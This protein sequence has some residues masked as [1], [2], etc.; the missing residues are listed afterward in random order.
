VVPKV[1][2]SRQ[3]SNSALAQRRLSP[4]PVSLR[5]ARAQLCVR[6]RILVGLSFVSVY[7]GIHDPQPVL[8]RSPSDKL[9]YFV[10]KGVQ[11]TSQG[12]IS[13]ACIKK[14]DRSLP[15]SLS[16]KS[17]RIGTSMHLFTSSRDWFC[18]YNIC[19]S[20][21][22]NFMPCLTILK[23]IIY[24]AKSPVISRHEI[25]SEF[26]IIPANSDIKVN[27]NISSLPTKRD[28]YASRNLIRTSYSMIPI[29]CLAGIRVKAHFIAYLMG[30]GF[31]ISP[32]PKF[33]GGGSTL[34]GS[35][36]GCSP[37]MML[38]E[39]GIELNSKVRLCCL[40]RAFQS[41]EGYCS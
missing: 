33:T 41:T 1:G 34:G 13:M 10:G 37:D 23:L 22:Q 24:K 20:A 6:K 19:R 18:R 14:K 31:P 21:T 35:S 11:D 4:K 7:Y 15:D 26:L 5:A 9:C 3:P 38:E 40:V 12:H 36:L 27:T 8:P 29:Q 32:S 28:E 39:R 25:A 30:L 2:S 17:C 16:C